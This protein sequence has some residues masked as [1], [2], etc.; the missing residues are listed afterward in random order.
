MG[1]KGKLV[2]ARSRLLQPLTRR[3]ISDEEVQVQA[4]PTPPQESKKLLDLPQEI[5]DQIVSSMV[6]SSLPIEI[7]LHP[8]KTSMKRARLHQRVDFRLRLCSISPG[9]DH[10][11]MIRRLRMMNLALQP[12]DW[13]PVARFP[14]NG[15]LNMAKTCR[16]LYITCIPQVYALAE[17]VFWDMI[18]HPW[19]PPAFPAFIQQI[20][21]TNSAY[22]TRISFRD[23]YPIEEIASL[24]LLPHL[25]EVRISLDAWLCIRVDEMMNKFCDRLKEMRSEEIPLS[26]RSLFVIIRVSEFTPGC[27]SLSMHIPVIFDRAPELED[28]IRTAKKSLRRF[29]KEVD[30][31]LFLQ[32][33]AGTRVLG[34]ERGVWRNVS[35]TVNEPCQE[36]IIRD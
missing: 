15:I 22:L 3:T 35:P 12:R 16:Q 21:P 30:V 32:S 31:G 5:L 26:L 14:G 4:P 2:K 10:P 9:Q 36:L 7:S 11:Q 29:K 17:F 27:G 6:L 23:V 28:A 34:S 20:G 33:Q 1:L 8:G 18:N 24:T 25:R 19:N 13:H